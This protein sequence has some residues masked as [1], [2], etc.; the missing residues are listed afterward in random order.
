MGALEI[1]FI[2]IIIINALVATDTLTAAVSTHTARR[3]ITSTCSCLGTCVPFNSPHSTLQNSTDALYNTVLMYL[4]TVQNSNMYFTALLMYFTTQYS[5]T[6]QHYLCTLQHSTHVLYNTAYVL[7]NTVLMYFTTLLMY[8]TTQYSCTLQHCLC[9]LQH[10]THVL[11]NTVMW[12]LAAS[13]PSSR[14]IIHKK[15]S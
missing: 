1:L 3:P 2:I 7:Y 4:T 5:C 15:A 13:V 6:L 10:S 14:S 11:Y 9:T 8:F 12:C